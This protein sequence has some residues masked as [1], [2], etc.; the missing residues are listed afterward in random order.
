MLSGTAAANHHRQLAARVRGGHG[1]LSLPLNGSDVRCTYNI[2]THRGR[3]GCTFPV[4][5]VRHW[6]VGVWAVTRFAF[7][8][9]V[10]AV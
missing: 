8:P 2:E 9:T 3:A 1:R 5:H 7:Q 4:T 6:I 10:W